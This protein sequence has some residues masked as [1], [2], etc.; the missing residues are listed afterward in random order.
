[1]KVTLLGTGT[2]I[3]DPNRAGPAQLIES[4][5][6][7]LLVDAGRGVV[8]RLAGA[9]VMPA[10]LSGVLITHLHSDHIS[11]LNDVITT[12]WV[13]AGDFMDLKVYGPEGI[14]AVVDSTLA[15]LEA[16][17]SY[18]LAHHDD[19]NQSPKV[20]VTEVQPGDTFELA[21]LKVAVGATD[22]RPVHPT[23]AYRVDDGAAS[24]VMAGDGIPCDTLDALCEGATAYCQA[25]LRDDLV[26]AIPVARIQ[27]ILDYHSSVD[28][29]AQT[30]ARAGVQT[31]ILTHYVPAPPLGEEEAFVAGAKAH[32]SGR[33]AC[34][35]DLTAVEI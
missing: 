16:D 17:V 24:V 25:V 1:M 21:G 6:A 27:D 19:L 26:K 15:M 7:K 4:G 31:L 33:V 10:F 18:R 20:T 32:F 22:H 28:Q 8:Q 29:A 30:A 11:D 5:D 3:P 23:V 34:G 2:P 14:A 35:P 12:I 9:G 13:M